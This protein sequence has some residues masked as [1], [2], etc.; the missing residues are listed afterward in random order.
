M[1]EFKPEINGKTVN[2]SS[3]E[4]NENTGCVNLTLDSSTH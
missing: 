4:N 3:Y 1:I 2:Y